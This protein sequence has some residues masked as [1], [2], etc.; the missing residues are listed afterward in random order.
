MSNNNHLIPRQER[1]MSFNNILD[2]ASPSSSTTGING[3]SSLDLISSSPKSSGTS[4][5]VLFR[6]VPNAATLIRST[7][8][9]SKLNHTS[10]TVVKKELFKKLVLFLEKTQHLRISTKY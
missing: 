9:R 7:M 2:S 1:A 3:I 5:N 6:H 10:S 4:S 8:S